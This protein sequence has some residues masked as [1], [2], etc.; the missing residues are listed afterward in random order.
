[1]KKYS[2]ILFLLVATVIISVITYFKNQPLLDDEIISINGTLRNYPFLGEQ[3]G[4]TPEPFIRIEI[5]E[6]SSNYYIMW[7]AYDV[8]K[9]EDILK[10]VPGST[11]TIFFKEIDKDKNAIDIYGLNNGNLELLKIDNYNQCY[12]HNWRQLLPFIYVMALIIFFMLVFDLYKTLF[13]CPT[14]EKGVEKK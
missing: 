5:N 3:G 12:T 7:C 9:T 8:A 11:I 1:M 10:L 4:D 14:N 2:T 6:S 13:K